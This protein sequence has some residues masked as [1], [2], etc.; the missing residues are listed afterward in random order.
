MRTFYFLT[1]FLCLLGI[2]S[3]EAGQGQMSNDT[4]PGT[5]EMGGGAQNGC[6]GEECTGGCAGSGG[7]D[8]TN[9]QGQSTNP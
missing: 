8:A 7:S 1:L 6:E 9:P 5:E 2:K 3:T 4:P